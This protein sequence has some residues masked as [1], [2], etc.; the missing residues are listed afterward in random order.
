[1]KEKTGFEVGV[2]RMDCGELKSNKM[3]E[4]LELKGTKQEFTAPYTSAHCGR[5]ERRHRTLMGKA[6]AMHIYT[7]CP[8]NLWDKFYLMASYLDEQTPT[9]SLKDGITP[10]EAYYNRR[11]D[12][13]R[14]REIGCRAFVLILSRHN[15]KIYDRSIE[16]I[17]IGYDSNSKMYRCYNK[18]MKQIYSSYHVRFIE[19]HNNPNPSTPS[20]PNPP[21][22]STPDSTPPTLIHFDEEEEFLPKNLEDPI[23]TPLG[24]ICDAR[25][26]ITNPHLHTSSTW[27]AHPEPPLEQQY[28]GA[29][30]HK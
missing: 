5:V 18:T 19:S 8:D 4:W 1:V 14:L 29:C 25:N 23:P 6:N 24:K 12:Y 3:K 16:C 7:D 20:I 21:T 27:C 2:Y 10:Y 17:L 22:S 13:G 9:A 15:P 28:D 26:H 30:S 11:P